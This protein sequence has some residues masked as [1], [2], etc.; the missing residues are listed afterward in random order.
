MKAMR[1][2]RCTARCILISV[3]QRHEGEFML[4]NRITCAERRKLNGKHTP[5]GDRHL[6]GNKTERQRVRIRKERHSRDGTGLFFPC[7]KGEGKI[8]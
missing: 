1:G 7:S 2:T 3:V 6:G 5:E 4:E 8:A